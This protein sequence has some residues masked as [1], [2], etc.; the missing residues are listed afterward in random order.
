M[1]KP[2]VRQ[3]NFPGVADGQVVVY[4]SALGEFVAG[5]V[6]PTMSF[7][8]QTATQSTTSLTPVPV[9]GM[10]I[11]PAAGTYAVWWDGTTYQSAKGSDSRFSLFKAGVEIESSRS[12]ST[13]G[14]TNYSMDFTCLARVTV[15]GSQSIDG[16]MSAPT[17]GTTSIAKCNMLI[18]KVSPV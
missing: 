4:D 18:M 14:G 13:A 12:D 10:S 3:L 9:A 17:G 1:A 7:L 8:E 5:G 16:R 11:T 15:N 6:L 2:D